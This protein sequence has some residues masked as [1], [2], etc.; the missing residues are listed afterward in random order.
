MLVRELLQLDVFQDFDIVQN[1]ATVFVHIS[2]ETLQMELKDFP[3]LPQKIL[4]QNRN[5]EILLKG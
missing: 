1:K 2:T 5:K 4:N 3:K